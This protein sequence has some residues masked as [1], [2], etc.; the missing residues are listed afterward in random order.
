MFDVSGSSSSS[1]EDRDHASGSEVSF[2]HSVSSSHAGELHA[3][4]FLHK[5]PSHLS[6]THASHALDTPAPQKHP[7]PAGHTAA[8]VSKAH[9]S[10]LPLVFRVQA[11][12]Q[13]R[14][15]HVPLLAMRKGMLDGLIKR[16]ATVP[17]DVI[18]LLLAASSLVLPPGK[19]NWTHVQSL[20]QQRRF[21]TLLSRATLET[22]P[23]SPSLLPPRKYL[24]GHSSPP[25]FE[26]S[27]EASQGLS[28]IH[29][30][31]V[32]FRAPIF[33]VA[34]IFTRNNLARRS[35]LRLSMPLRFIRAPTKALKLCSEL[36]SAVAALW[37][38]IFKTVLLHRQQKI[39]RW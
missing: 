1:D 13:Q 29:S 31:L 4:A 24:S 3:E 7:R 30:W 11:R 19:A 2:E 26:A 38:S 17:T 6:A 28:V 8:H 12:S 20:I 33:E 34:S 39:R 10:S 27:A 15:P 37:P 21:I 16:Y 18:S 25:V 14:G 32:P 23:Q 36:L 9:P 5:S 22:D 35:A